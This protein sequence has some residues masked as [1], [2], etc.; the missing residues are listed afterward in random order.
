M[1]PVLAE[2][3]GACL[4]YF[5][6]FFKLINLFNSSNASTGFI[7][8]EILVEGRIYP[9]PEPLVNLFNGNSL[10]IC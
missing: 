4:I 2:M 10:L 1:L 5:I 6:L 7:Q 8:E 3:R 9:M